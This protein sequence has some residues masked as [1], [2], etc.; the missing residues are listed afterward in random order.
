MS[1]ELSEAVV[2]FAD[3]LIDQVLGNLCIMGEIDRPG[4]FE[5]V[6][7]VKTEEVWVTLK[8]VHP[9]SRKRWKC[10][11]YGGEVYQTFFN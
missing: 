6:G 7:S 2:V 11:N 4:W 8:Y 3:I 5:L 10:A 1:G 9:T